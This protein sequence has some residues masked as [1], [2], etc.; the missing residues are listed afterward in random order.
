[1]G[2]DLGRHVIVAQNMAR[3]AQSAGLALHDEIP[4]RDACPFY[5]WV[6]NSE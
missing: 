2:R 1:V 6:A 4:K 5:Q 3:I